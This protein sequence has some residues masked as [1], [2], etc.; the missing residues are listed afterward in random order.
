VI[1]VIIYF[2]GELFIQ[3]LKEFKGNRSQYNVAKE[4]GINNRSTI[5]L[6]ENGKQIP[7]LEVLQKLCE[8]V[9][10]PVDTFFAKEEQSPVLMMM[11]QLKEADRVKLE[12]VISRIKIREKYI[13][14]SKRCD[15]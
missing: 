6:L 9:N 5:S 15:K 8:K 2:N 14:I 11:G 13:A 7:S 3:K 10:L 4:L 12:N 1:Q